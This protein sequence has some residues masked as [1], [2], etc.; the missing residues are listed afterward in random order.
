MKYIMFKYILFCL[1]IT[2]N[3]VIAKAQ[4]SG[5]I[6]LDVNVNGKKDASSLNESGIAGIRV[7]GYNNQNQEIGSVLS[8]EDGSYI[9]DVPKNQRVKLVYSNFSNE[10]STTSSSIKFVESPSQKSDLGLIKNNLF[11]GDNPKFISSIFLNG[12][13]QKDLSEYD[14]PALV[15]FNPNAKYD[16]N[17]FKKTKKRDFEV[18]AKVSDVGSVWGLAYNPIT[19][20]VFASAFLKRHVGLGSLGIDGIY[21]TDP[22]TKQTKPFLKLSDSGVDVGDNLHKDLESKVYS[23]SIDNEA[24]ANIGKVGIGGMDWSNDGKTLYLINLKDKT[25]YGLDFK[26]NEETIA[27]DGKGMGIVERTNKF[28]LQDEMV[29]GGEIRPFAVKVINGDVYIGAVKDGSISQNLQ[30]LKAIVYKLSLSKNNLVKVIDI[31]LDYPRGNALK[32]SSI[33]KWNPWND[34]FNKVIETNKSGVVIYPQP[35]LS[36]IEMD[37]DGN[38]IIALMDR[39]GHQVGTGQPAP[40]GTGSYIGVS[41]GDILKAFRKK[42]DVFLL[43]SNASLGK[44]GE[45]QGKNNEQGPANGE[46]YFQESFEAEGRVIHDENGTG[47]IAYNPNTDEILYAVHEPINE[48]FNN[49]GVIWM[50][51]KTGKSL[52]GLPFFGDSEKGTFSKVNAIGDI[53]ML[54]ESLPIIASNRIWMDCNENGI[55]E[56]DELPMTNVAVELWSGNHN[57][58][59]VK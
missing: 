1:L 56:S 57:I 12:Q 7:S 47:S 15:Q 21:Q 3:S 17:E 32:G 2:V 53:E 46:F 51:N 24:F 8:N 36:D 48:E 30:D 29:Q 52:K 50:D 33:R 54:T 37:R 34:D 16:V 25:L 23:T 9:L 49:S 22:I 14:A 5:K 31:S 27:I 43:E 35:I 58:T 44:N 26:F 28:P 39:F 19:K 18:L 13:P 6:Y 20:C 38:M 59:S 4:I 42:K 40:D 55:Q 10:W 41:S 45:T 11:I